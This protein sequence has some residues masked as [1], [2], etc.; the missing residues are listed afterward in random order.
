MLTNTTI[1]SDGKVAKAASAES[2]RS[3][4]PGSD[5]VFYS[6]QTEHSLV[7]ADGESK[8]H[9]LHCGKEVHIVTA[10][11]EH[12]SVASRTSHTDVSDVF[13]YNK[14]YHYG[15][16]TQIFYQLCLSRT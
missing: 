3:V 9:C 6:E 2:L 12:D 4:S 13:V 11:H 8:A 5:S 16:S 10:A 1:T 15:C 14:K 7:G